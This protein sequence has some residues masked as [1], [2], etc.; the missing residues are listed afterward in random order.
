VVQVLR[1]DDDIAQPRCA[2]LQLAIAQA[3][4]QLVERH[5]EIGVLHLA[6]QRLLQAALEAAWGV[7]VQLRIGQK[8]GLEEGEPLDVI[9]VSV[10]EQ[11]MKLQRPRR[12]AKQ[13]LAKRPRA[14]AA[15]ENDGGAVVGAHFHTGGVAAIAVGVRSGRRDRATRAPKTDV[16]HDF[17]CSP[18]PIGRARQ[19]WYELP[20]TSAAL[21]E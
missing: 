17:P 16:H 10:S 15:V 9:P 4:A 12:G 7:A 14:G 3:T 1:L 8:R 13:V 18:V 5:G 19:P 20:T 21:A 6:G 2:L 11:Q